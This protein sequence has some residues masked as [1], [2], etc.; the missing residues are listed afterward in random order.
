VQTPVECPDGTPLEQRLQQP[1]FASQW[2]AGTRQRL[3]PELQDSA[4][5]AEWAATIEDYRRRAAGSRAPPDA[6]APAPPPAAASPAAAAAAA[7]AAVAVAP[8]SAAV[9]GP[10]PSKECDGILGVPELQCRAALPPHLVLAPPNLGG[11]Q[12]GLRTQPARVSS[13]GTA[14]AIPGMYFAMPQPQALLQLACSADGA[15]AA[16]ALAQPLPVS[17]AMMSAAVSAAMASAAAAA[18]VSQQQLLLAGLLAGT[19][20]ATT[21]GS[22]GSQRRLSFHMPDS[23]RGTEQRRPDNGMFD[24]TSDRSAASPA[25]APPPTWRTKRLRT[26]GSRKQQRTAAALALPCRPRDSRLVWREPRQLG[27]R[28]WA[29]LL[30]ASLIAL[31]LR[32]LLDRVVRLPA[33]YRSLLIAK[34]SVTQ[35]RKCAQLHLPMRVGCICAVHPSTSLM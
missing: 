17:P 31:P 3:Q 1:A 35:L 21:G 28:A 2:L 24:L 8:Q 16:A 15:A 25:L 18:A 29:R 33:S 27:R 26:G 9:A 5:T 22:H 6:M 30:Q 13:T 7:A 20:V 11:M 32:G 10:Q 19:L 23:R 14:Y 12:H 34:C 4:H